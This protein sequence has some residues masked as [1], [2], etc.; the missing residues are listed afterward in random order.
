MGD[1]LTLENHVTVDSDVLVTEPD[2][3]DAVVHDIVASRNSDGDNDSD[4]HEDVVQSVSCTMALHAI[5]TLKKFTTER[6]LSQ[7]LGHLDALE[8]DTVKLM[9]E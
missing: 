6:G 2:T 1:A 7:Y 5:D 8:R 4:E 3:D 9:L